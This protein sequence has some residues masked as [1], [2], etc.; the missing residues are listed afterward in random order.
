[1]CFLYMLFKIL[2]Q[3][4]ENGGIFTLFPSPLTPGEDKFLKV[5][6]RKSKWKK[7]KHTSA[8]AIGCKAISHWKNV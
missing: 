5:E 8:F 4:L 6:K 1:M 7:M 2:V 3:L